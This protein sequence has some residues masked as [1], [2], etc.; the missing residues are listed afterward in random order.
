M[1]RVGSDKKY[2]THI[3]PVFLIGTYIVYSG[4]YFKIGDFLG[5][6]GDFYKKGE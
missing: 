5:E 3:Q 1:K 6:M 2:S 4:R